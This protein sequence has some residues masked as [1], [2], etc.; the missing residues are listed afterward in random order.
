MRTHVIGLMLGAALVTAPVKAA[1][2]EPVGETYTTSRDGGGPFGDAA[3]IRVKDE[4]GDEERIGFLRFDASA[5]PVPSLPEH[6]VLNLNPVD[7]D[8]GGGPVGDATF[9]LFVTTMDFDPDA[10]VVADRGPYLD[11]ATSVGEFSLVNTGQG[12]P[13][14]FS[15]YDLTDF[16]AANPDAITLII[17][18]T[19]WDGGTYVHGFAS[20][21]H[22]TVP[23]PTM[24][25]I[26]EP[27]TVMLL[28]IGAAGLLCRR[29]SHRV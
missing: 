14:E 28:G 4:G 22:D 27:A 5:A 21:R 11:D 9:E 10:L 25:V 7:T 6:V 17:R 29:R 18:R 8:L 19:A 16:V 13:V 26:P 1:V 15:S 23:G 3:E 2:I 20:S 24:T 12:V